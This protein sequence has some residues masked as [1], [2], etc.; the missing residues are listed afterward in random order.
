MILTCPP[1]LRA[2][3][4]RRRLIFYFTNS[5]TKESFRSHSEDRLIF[6]NNLGYLFP[7]VKTLK[8]SSF[9]NFFVRIYLEE[10]A[11]ERLMRSDLECS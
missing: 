9:P 2:K 5:T 6:L 7:Y 10:G 3:S 1:F 4:V 8:Q 11:F